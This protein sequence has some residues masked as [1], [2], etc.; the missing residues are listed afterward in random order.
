MRYLATDSSIFSVFTAAR[1]TVRLISERYFNKLAI[2]EG[3]AKREA[4]DGAERIS[5]SEIVTHI[6]TIHKDKYNYSKDK[7]YRDIRRDWSLL[8]KEYPVL[9]ELEK[10]YRYFNNCLYDR[11]GENINSY[12]AE[13]DRSKYPHCASFVKGI[14]SDIVAIK[15]GMISGFDSGFVEGGNNAFKHVKGQGY[16]RM[17]IGMLRIKFLLRGRKVTDIFLA[18]NVPR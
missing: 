1:N 6:T 9:P 10:F 3:K 11:S 8:R 4:I 18:K 13:F 17:K 5:R 16:G 14:K 15:E 12:I 7:K 2:D